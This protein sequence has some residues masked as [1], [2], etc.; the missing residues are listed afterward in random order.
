MR[1]YYLC[2]LQVLLSTAVCFFYH[3]LVK[4][5]KGSFTCKGEKEKVK[6]LWDP[7]SLLYFPLFIL[8]I[9]MSLP[10][11]TW[12]SQMYSLEFGSWMLVCQSNSLPFH[13]V[14]LFCV[15]WP[16]T[17]K[18]NSEGT[19]TKNVEI[20]IKI[21]VFAPFLSSTLCFEVRYFLDFF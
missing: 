3:L 12:N 4:E 16:T 7:S 5:R 1:V 17:V 2:F 10:G 8:K 14:V 20:F 15:C 9:F 21:R 18:L 11:Y 6:Q 19:L 13:F